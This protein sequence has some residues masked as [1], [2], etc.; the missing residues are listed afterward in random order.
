MNSSLRILYVTSELTPLLSTGG[1]AEVAAALPP[2]LQAAGH[3]IRVAMPCYRQIPRD[4]RGAILTR[5]E[6]PS[7]EGTRYGALHRS[8][9]PNTTI[10][11]YLIEHEDYF[12]RDDPYGTSSY[13]YPDNGERFSFF[14][15]ALLDSMERIDWQPDIIHCNDWQTAALPVFLKTQMEARPFWMHTATLMT[16][17]NLA[18]QGRFS[19]DRLPGTGLDS[20]LY[21]SGLL[22][23]EGD[24]NMLKGA[25]ILCDQINTVSPRYAQEIQTVDYGAGLH[26]VLASR[27]EDLH[28]ILNGVDYDLWHPEK[29]TLIAAPY[30]RENMEGK[31]LCKEV[32]QDLFMLPRSDAPLFGIVS[33]L[34]WQKGID[35]IVDSLEQIL[36]QDL[37]LVILGSGESALEEKIN[38]A[39]CTWPERMAVYI[40]FDA[41]R[42]HAIQAGS[43]FF[44]MPSRYEPCGLSQLYALAYGTIPI[45]RRT[46][47]LADTVF[48]WR[49]DIAD[50]SRA[51][52][53]SFV[54]RTPQALYRSLEK[55]LAL[56]QNPE[57]L[58]ELQQRGMTMDYSW[59]RSCADYVRLYERCLQKRQVS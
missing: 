57:D 19:P 3:D 10:P 40:G 33:R 46:G 58:Q 18:F 34:H 43:D 23:F 32:L 47:G 48:P 27:R 28:G 21:H 56:Y 11:L 39:A 45:V 5:C 2:R 8:L 4:A 50:N 24:V 59:K 22:E 20:A 52:G 26:E 38:Q 53:I 55:A 6:A 51:T 1:L 41:K 36:E 15:S 31:K 54:P 9:V 49:P 16:I 42:A 13:E 14:C 7:A 17:H 30:S 12:G 44:L 29:D 25:L 35:L 37:Q